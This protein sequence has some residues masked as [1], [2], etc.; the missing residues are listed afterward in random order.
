METPDNG[1][2]LSFNKNPLP[3]M[4]T[5]LEKQGITIYGNHF[6]KTRHV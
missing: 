1:N 2:P 3:F 6:W 4:K 5:I